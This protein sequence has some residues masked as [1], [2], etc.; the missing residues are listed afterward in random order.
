MIVEV[1][2]GWLIIAIWLIQVTITSIYQFV[3]LSSSSRYYRQDNPPFSFKE[4][5]NLLL[6]PVIGVFL[7]LVFKTR[8]F[9]KDNKSE[10]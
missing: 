3:S 1:K 6:I 4:L 10:K 2:M 9:E 5:C 8:K 7:V